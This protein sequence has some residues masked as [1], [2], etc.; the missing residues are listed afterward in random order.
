[1]NYKSHYD[2]LIL[3]AQNR[4]LAENTYTEMHH[5]L[6]KCAGG[7]NHKNNLVAL[8]PEEHLLAHL[9]LVKI[10]PLNES[11]IFA[12]NMMT[13]RIRNNKEYGWVRRAYS[14]AASRNSL[15]RTHT[16]E[17][18]KRISEARTGMTFEDDHR[19]NISE[20]VKKQWA[21]PT[22]REKFIKCATGKKHSEETKQKMSATRS[23]KKRGPMSEEQKK[24][25]SELKT[26]KKL[27]P[28][29]PMSEETKKKISE[30]K[31]KRATNSLS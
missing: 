2:K 12:A 15:G 6:P 9:L 18:K 22:I 25:I 27:P 28:R 23:G 30:A 10:D 8:L 19:K 21:D 1:M 11:Y 24:K 13:H 20:A 3:K 17:T 31:R 29:G 14:I 26:G 16:E 4:V 5:I 7:T